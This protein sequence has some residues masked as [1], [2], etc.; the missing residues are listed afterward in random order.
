MERP[1]SFRDTAAFHLANS[2]DLWSGGT[3][4]APEVRLPGTGSRTRAATPP[5]RAPVDARPPVPN[6]IPTPAIPAGVGS[7]SAVPIPPRPPG[8][9]AGARRARVRAAAAAVCLVLGIGLIGG[10]AAG[11]WLANSSDARPAAEAAFTKGRDVW[12]NASVDTIFPRTLNSLGTGPGGADRRWTRIAV[13]PDSGCAGAFDP[14][15]A[16][17]LSPVG[18]A[19]LLRATYADATRTG[20]VTVGAQITTADRTAMQAL[21]TRFS[22]E[23]LTA[24][25]DLMP[26]P[27]TAQGTLAAGFGTA[28]RASWSV[29]VLT[30]LP[31]VVY[32]VSGFADGRA[33]ADPQ[34]A[35]AATR[36]GATSTPA[37][38]G[39]GHGAKDLADHLEAAFRKASAGT[40]RATEA[41]K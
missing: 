38:S 18:C 7:E 34:D 29:R 15:L 37:Q 25:T 3:G 33:V 5:P 24:R 11:S 16:K 31:V 22:T 39:L 27:Y 4:A 30:D 13:A 23:K 32:A 1:A 26:R 19:R 28:Q 10:A 21:R 20:V 40:P 36:P 35:E 9:P 8:A 12:H 2:Q 17:A 6:E 41:T 14:L